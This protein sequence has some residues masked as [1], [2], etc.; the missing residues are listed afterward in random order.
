[1]TL[2]NSPF[3]GLVPPSSAVLTYRWAY[4]RPRFERL[5]ESLKI[6]ADQAEDGETK[7]KGVV[8]AL[9]RAYYGNRHDTANRVLI[10]SWGKATR[11]RPPRDIDLLFMPPVEVYYQ[12][13]Q[14]TGNKQSQ[15]L[16][17][18]AAV[19]RDTYPQT[20]IRGDGQVVVIGF[21]TYRVEVAPAFYY[22][23]GGVLI[24]DTNNGGRWKHVDS[25]GEI[26]ALDAADRLHNGNV[27]KLTRILKQWQRRCDVP[28][29]SFHLEA[30]VKELLPTKTYGGNDEFWFDWLVRDA[31][32]HMICRANGGFSMPGCAPEWIWLGDAWLSKAQTAYDRAL[33]ACAYEYD[34][35]DVLAGIEWQKIFGTMIPLA[36]G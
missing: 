16:Q 12:F 25:E 23:P 21:N 6:T 24:C 29:K 17:D 15:L 32:A 4:V 30:L 14:R 33:K 31:F 3:L 20:V 1:M 13:D 2:L 11:V 35:D 26:A 7:H 9:N 5:L 8:S 10:G 27:R 19:L 34:N 28:I 22:Q 36:A 18:V